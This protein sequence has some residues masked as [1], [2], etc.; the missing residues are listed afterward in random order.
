MAWQ[1]NGTPATVSGTSEIYDN[2]GDSVA[3]NVGISN[4]GQNGQKA[5]TRIQTGNAGIGK[6]VQK[7]KV[8]LQRVG[9]PT[10][11]FVARIWDASGAVLATS[12]SFDG[13]LISVGVYDTLEL[14]TLSEIT[15][16]VPVAQM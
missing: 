7:L 11:F 15:V 8:Q 3:S 4:S 6:K 13:A 1:V 2:I 10:G 5:A 12:A 14:D 16:F 9:S